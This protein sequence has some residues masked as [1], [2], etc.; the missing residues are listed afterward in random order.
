MK[1]QEIQDYLDGVVLK[2][3]LSD[4]ERQQ[5]LDLIKMPGLALLLGLHL[6]ERQGYY[7]QF[8]NIKADDPQRLGVLQG[9]ITGIERTAQTLL[10][11]ATAP[12]EPEGTN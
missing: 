3:E 2:T 8:R 6:G 12:A 10:E 4:H 5:V 11:C 1:A 9:Q 7:A